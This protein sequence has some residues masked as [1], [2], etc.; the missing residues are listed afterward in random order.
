[1]NE[2][3]EQIEKNNTWE[4]VPRTSTRLMKILKYVAEEKGHES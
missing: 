1:M 3:L 2:E 4:L